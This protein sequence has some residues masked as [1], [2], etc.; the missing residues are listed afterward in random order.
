MP[1]MEKERNPLLADTR[2][3]WNPRCSRPLSDEDARQIIKNT[4]GFF[5]ILQEWK[6]ADICPS[7]RTSALGNRPGSLDHGGGK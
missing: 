6:A 5:R 4:V 7:G 1:P 3:V 2:K